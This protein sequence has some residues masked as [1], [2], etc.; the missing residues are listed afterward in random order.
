MIYAWCYT[1]TII[2][3]SYF[4]T[5]VVTSIIKYLTLIL[6]EQH[7]QRIITN[8]TDTQQVPSAHPRTTHLQALAVLECLLF[9]YSD[10]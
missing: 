4:D 3:C 1:V 9:Q 6:S 2:S 10:N 5:N 7:I 8:L